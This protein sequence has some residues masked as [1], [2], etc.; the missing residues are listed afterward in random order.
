MHRSSKKK[1]V[2][3]DGVLANQWIFSAK[4]YL[5]QGNDKVPITTVVPSED[6]ENVVSFFH[7]RVANELKLTFELYTEEPFRIV[8]PTVDRVRVVF[9]QDPEIDDIEY[10]VF[11]IFQDGAQDTYLEG[12][13][14]IY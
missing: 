14:E 12:D 8:W 13:A 2:L 11:G 5:L 9:D 7:D 1:T 4:A 6:L 3:R 10:N